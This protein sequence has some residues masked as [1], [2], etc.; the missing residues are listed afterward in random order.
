MIVQTDMYVNV[1]NYRT[2]IIIYLTKQILDGFTFC[3]RLIVS[4]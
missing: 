2:R 3:L 4:E 1:I